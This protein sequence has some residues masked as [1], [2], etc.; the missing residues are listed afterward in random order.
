MKITEEQLI[1]KIYDKA[2][3]K[4]YYEVEAFLQDIINNPIAKTMKLKDGQNLSGFI[5]DLLES[6][7]FYEAKDRLADKYQEQ[8]LSHAHDFLGL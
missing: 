1:N 6:K 5:V 4:A 3:E 8:L 2:D 7:S